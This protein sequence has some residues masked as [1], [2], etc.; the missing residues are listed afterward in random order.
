LTGRKRDLRELKIS[1]NLGEGYNDPM[2]FVDCTVAADRYGFNTVWFGDHLL[3]WIHS[4]NKSA[5]VW[6]VMPIAL[7]RTKHV[8]VGVL[9]TSPIGGRYHPL[10]IGQAAATLDNMFPGRFRLGV[11]SGEAVSE[12]Y[13]FRDGFP[14]WAERM[15][16]LVEGVELMRTM[17]TKEDFFLPNGI[18]FKT[19]AEFFLY[20]KPKK[21]IPIYFAAQ[22]E[23]GAAFAGVYGDHLVTINS[24]ETCRNVVFPAFEQ[25]AKG[26]GRDLSKMD[27]MVELQLHFSN[28]ES[29]VQEIKSSGGAGFLSKDSFEQSDPRK[30]QKLSKTLS[31][32]TIVENWCFISS[33]EDLIRTVEKYQRA[34]STHVELVTD[35]F[36]ERIEYIG[37]KVLP[38]FWSK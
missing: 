21:T 6:S 27:K 23:K 14:R 9:V 38:Y 28:Q 1:I 3:P 4:Q 30:V 8:N 25:A 22:G 7:D 33:P 10:V 24:A 37:K 36:P 19:E 12:S 15:S 29:G 35:S 11:G 16:R 31:D 13:F 26:A 5:F 34:G 2:R 32:E 17:W 20:T 18:H